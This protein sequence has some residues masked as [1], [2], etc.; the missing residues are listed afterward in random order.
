MFILDEARSPAYEAEGA[1][2]SD[3][4]YTLRRADGEPATL[5]YQNA[6]TWAVATPC[7]QWKLVRTF[8]WF[9]KELRVEGGPFDGAILAGSLLTR[10]F[11][12]TH[13][14]AVL[15]RVD[16]NISYAQ[17]EHRVTLL[18]PGD[19]AE[20]LAVTTAVALIIQQKSASAG[21]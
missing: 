5:R 19:Q 17:D 2:L 16:G 6:T 15:A 12:I 11:T 7:G 13:G 10:R 4:V 1:F 3:A 21:D 14:G 18:V 20:W 8:R 9:A